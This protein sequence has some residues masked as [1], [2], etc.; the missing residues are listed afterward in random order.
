MFSFQ[1]G[2]DEVD[3]AEHGEAQ[4][5]AGRAKREAWKEK[6]E[7][8]SRQA[9]WESGASK[10]S[11]VVGGGRRA[12]R[13]WRGEITPN[14]HKAI[15]LRYVQGHRSPCVIAAKVDEIQSDR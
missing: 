10:K 12:L 13:A 1:K 8:Q 2:A 5:P 7:G 4:A 3:R 15:H 6:Q 9:S 14:M 11:E